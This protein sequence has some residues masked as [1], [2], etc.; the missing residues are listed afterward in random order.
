MNSKYQRVVYIL[1][2]G[3]GARFILIRFQSFV[4]YKSHAEM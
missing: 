1:I 4:P 3:E 2:L